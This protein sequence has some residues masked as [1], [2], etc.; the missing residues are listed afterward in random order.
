M[1]K[2]IALAALL[3]A[4]AGQPVF[5]QGFP[6]MNSGPTEVGV[7]EVSVA[8]V[9]F[10]ITLPG[11]AVAYE[12]TEI[13]PRV[14]GLIEEIVYT[15]GRPVSSGDVLF[16]LDSETYEA[17]LASAEAARDSAEAG[18]STAQASYD[19]YAKL[20]GVGASTSELEAARATLAQAKAEVKS[21]EASLQTAQLNL[22]RVDIT[23]PITGIPDVAQFSVGSLV[24]ANQSDTLTTVTR[25]DPIYVDVSESSARRMRIRE[26]F[27]DGSLSPGEELDVE[28]TL[29]NGD[30][31]VEKGTLVTPGV[32]VSTTTGTIDLR[33][34]FPNPDRMIL[35]GQFLRVDITLGTTQAILVPQRATTRQS[36][37]TLTAFVA[38]DGKAEQVTLTY[39]GS[40]QNAWIVTDGIEAGDQVILEGLSN[41][42]DGAEITT[43]PVIINAEGVVEDAETAESE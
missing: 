27:S 1:R 40:Y 36:D 14:E 5:S 8:D 37:G 31:S 6:G 20:E 23:S 28:L 25:L 22:A 15:P 16:R 30:V 18:L 21:A 13:R 11:R 3:A 38:Q 7:M 2:M 43:V 34:E 33:F 35:P 26:L 9:P 4:T 19:R 32:T 42:R 12:E 10:T 41:L 29:E 39:S 17:A 24:T